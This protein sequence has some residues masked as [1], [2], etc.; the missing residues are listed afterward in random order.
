MHAC[1]GAG[2]ADLVVVILSD[3]QLGGGWL[4]EIACQSWGR[5]GERIHVLRRHGIH[6]AVFAH[7]GALCLCF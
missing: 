2:L 1:G 7:G 4:H 3:R 6:Q 5:E